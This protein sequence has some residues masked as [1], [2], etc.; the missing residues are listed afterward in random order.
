MKK[1][2][3]TIT[4]IANELPGVLRIG[5]TG[6]PIYDR[7][8][9]LFS[10]CNWL[11]PFYVGSSY[12]AFVNMFC[13]VAEDFWGRKPAGLSKDPKKVE[14][15]RRV[16]DCF[17][18]RNAVDLGIGHQEITVPIELEPAQKRVYKDI[19]RLAVEV[20][21]DQGITVAN[22]VAQLVRLQQVVSNPGLF[23]L[24]GNPKFEWIL[25]FLASNPGE[26]IVVFSIYR[27]TILAFNEACQK[28]GFKYVSIHGEVPAKEREENKQIFI[29][30]KDVWVLSGTVGAMGESIDGLQHVCRTV[31]F[32][33]Q[34]WSPEMNNQAKRRVL[35]LGQEQFVSTYILEGIGTVDKKVGK[36]LLSKIADIKEVLEQC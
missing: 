28:S 31:I 30:D 9:D 29:R 34:D 20:L 12:W 19:K 24:P 33:D 25:D 11:N 10:I 21:L 3:K 32:I 13:T 35:R 36:V 16:L 23:N 14:L 1:N 18:V 2:R 22:G 7:P 27:E 4:G 17:M 26:K 15:L 6:S 5:L 8:D